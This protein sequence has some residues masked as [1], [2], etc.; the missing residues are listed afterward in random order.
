M[1]YGNELLQRLVAAYDGAAEL[2]EQYG[3]EVVE[4][5]LYGISFNAWMDIVWISGLGVVFLIV[6]SVLLWL[7][8]RAGR[9]SNPSSGDEVLN[10][11]GLLFGGFS[12][13]AAIFALSQV[14]PH[15]FPALHPDAYVA[16][17]VLL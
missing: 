13:V 12:M 15:L 14:P 16:V 17:R 10:V 3:A 1:D 11:A 6:G 5:T 7:G 4:R 2:V 9:K 8:I